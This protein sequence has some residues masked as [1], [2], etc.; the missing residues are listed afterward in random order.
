M[1]EI[2]LENE[3]DFD[4]PEYRELFANAS[5]TAFQHPEWLAPLYRSLAPKLNAEPL[6]AVARDSG[7]GSLTAVIP[8]M[9]LRRRSIKIVELADLGVTDYCAPVVRNGSQKTLYSDDRIASQ[10]R[11]AISPLD[12]FRAK[13]VRPEHA[14]LVEHITGIPAMPADF[15]AHEAPMDTVYENWRAEAFGKSHSRNLD[16][17]RRKFE[18]LGDTRLELVNE[19]DEARSAIAALRTLRAGRFDRDPIQNDCVFDFYA[20]VAAT[21][22]KSGFA[23]TYRLTENGNTAGIVFGICHNQRFNYLLIGCDYDKY[24]KY[25]PGLLMYDQIMSDW[26]AAGGNIFDFTIGDEPFKVDFGTRQVRIAAYNK[27]AS[28]A[29]HVAGSIH[30]MGKRLA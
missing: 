20:T 7:S 21:G 14:A 11:A 1:N 2:S 13:S 26:S 15:S 10:L 18:R 30:S 8:L 25:S 22:C 28:I 3:L 27:A 23:R 9:R 6:V 12:I 24:S 4:G 19:A 17:K 5:A 16:R 29:G